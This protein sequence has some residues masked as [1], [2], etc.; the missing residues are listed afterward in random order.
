VVVE[1]EELVMFQ[2]IQDQQQ[3]QIQDL[4]VVGG[5]AEIVPLVV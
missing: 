2:E 3:L 5:L 4:V 1:M